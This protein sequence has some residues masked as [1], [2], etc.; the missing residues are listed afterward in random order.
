LKVKYKGI[1]NIKFKKKGKKMKSFKI[2]FIML[3]TLFIL[4]C[5]KNNEKKILGKWESMEE[6]N[7]FM[8]YTTDGNFITSKGIT[9]NYKIL[10]DNLIIIGNDTAVFVIDD[11]IL[12]VTPKNKWDPV[13]F[14]KVIN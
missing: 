9:L 2:F 4:S 3:I 1:N 8:E 7:Y 5:S 13:K 11:N 10:D 6:K 12:T 14:K